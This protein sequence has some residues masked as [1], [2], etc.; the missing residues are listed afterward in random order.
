MKSTFVNAQNICRR[1]EAIR[2]FL[3]EIFLNTC[4]SPAEI[5]H[6]R[7]VECSTFEI[8]S[9]TDLNIIHIVLAS[10]FHPKAVVPALNLKAAKVLRWHQLTSPNVNPQKVRVNNMA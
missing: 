10:P 4:L 8:D 1:L 5:S 2:N 3:H 9:M 6:H 7:D